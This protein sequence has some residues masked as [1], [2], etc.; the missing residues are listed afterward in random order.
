VEI[1]AKGFEKIIEI[2]DDDTLDSVMEAGQLAKTSGLVCVNLVVRSQR[3]IDLFEIDS[4]GQGHGATMI[5]MT[6]P[7]VIK[8]SS[9]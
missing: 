2:D 6:P 3:T 9:Q 4:V 1:Q 8:V 7:I 5:G